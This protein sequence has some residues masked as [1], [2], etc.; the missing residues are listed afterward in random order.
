[1]NKNIK[2]PFRVAELITSYVHSDIQS[3]RPL[4]RLED[5]I[6]EV[7][8]L[9]NQRLRHGFVY[10]RVGNAPEFYRL[11]AEAVNAY[12]RIYLNYEALALAKYDVNPSQLEDESDKSIAI[13]AWWD[14]SLSFLDK[15]E[16]WCSLKADDL[17]PDELPYSDTTVVEIIENGLET[18]LG[19]DFQ[20]G[21]LNADTEEVV[22]NNQNNDAINRFILGSF[23]SLMET[24]A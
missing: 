5:V 6:D 22:W 24:Y 1:M 20:S 19:P 15:L 14:R 9:S 10:R 23:I 18:V 16:G 7:L 3:N 13:K 11:M 17:S 2:T 8:D 4:M 21:P 12:R